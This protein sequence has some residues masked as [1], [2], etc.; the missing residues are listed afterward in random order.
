MKFFAAAVIST[1]GSLCTNP[2]FAADYCAPFSD[3]ASEMALLFIDRADPITT[4]VTQPIEEQLLANQINNA[5]AGPLQKHYCRIGM[6]QLD[7]RFVQ[8]VLDDAIKAIVTEATYTWD[9]QQDP[10]GWVL[11]RMR[12]HPACARSA[13]LFAPTCN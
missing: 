9:A 11:S 5:E 1:L 6:F 13:M 7:I 4:R 12:S 8:P 10:A 3:N 2:A